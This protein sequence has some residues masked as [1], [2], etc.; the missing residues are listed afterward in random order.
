MNLTLVSVVALLTALSLAGAGV[1]G[2]RFGVDHAAALA[3][4]DQEVAR[5]QHEKE[6]NDYI[7]RAD[8]A[9]AARAAAEAQNT[10]LTGR[11]KNALRDSTAGRACLSARAVGLLNDRI[12]STGGVPATPAEPAGG[13]GASSTDTDVA[14]WAADVIAK[15]ESCR[16]QLSAAR[17]ANGKPTPL[18]TPGGGG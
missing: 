17:A 15:Y 4:K 9:Q 12:A 16:A 10:T 13:P 14:S 8:E 6:L 11:L 3:A 7:K 1:G 5:L 18:A 2:Y